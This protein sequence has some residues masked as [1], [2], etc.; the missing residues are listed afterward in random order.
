MK[1]ITLW[2]AIATV[3]HILLILLVVG[4]PTLVVIIFLIV[5]YGG[6]GDDG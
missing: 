5:R 4:I 6:D 1:Q 3:V 2:L